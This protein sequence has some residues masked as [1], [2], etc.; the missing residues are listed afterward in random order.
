MRPRCSSISNYGSAY[1]PKPNPVCCSEA[2][3][4]VSRFNEV[5]LIEVLAKAAEKWPKEKT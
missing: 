3:R 4:G 5:L 2:T 1:V